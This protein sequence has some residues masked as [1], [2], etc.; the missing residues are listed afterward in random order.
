MHQ[1]ELSRL[2]IYERYAKD[3]LRDRF[4]VALERHNWLVWINLL[5]MPLFFAAGF[6]AGVAVRR[7]ARPRPWRPGSAS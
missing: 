5:Q 6:A 4:Y 2:G 1:P 7:D 3:I